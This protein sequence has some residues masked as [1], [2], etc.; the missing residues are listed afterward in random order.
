LWCVWGLRAF[1]ER[2]FVFVG[3]Y[4]GITVWFGGIRG[5]I[6]D[7][8]IYMF[9]LCYCFIGGGSIIKGDWL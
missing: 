4:A 9:L 3:V 7:C 5:A 8:G 1:I 2:L 6:W